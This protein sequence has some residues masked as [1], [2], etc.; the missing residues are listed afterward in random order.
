MRNWLTT[1]VLAAC[2]SSANFAYS[3]DD[4]LKWR[5]LPPALST[6]AIAALLAGQPSQQG[7]YIL[8]VKLEK[9]GIIEPHF[10]RDARH[11]TVLRGTLY[12][13]SGADMSE[14][15]ATAYSAGEFFI[16][17]AGDVHFSWAKDGDVVYQESGMGP[18]SNELYKP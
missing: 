8:R 16:I 11:V 9:D 6:T 2:L 1:F 4:Q 18:T 15:N 10:H 13:G 5:P 12:A 14:D 3:A 7:L 17:P